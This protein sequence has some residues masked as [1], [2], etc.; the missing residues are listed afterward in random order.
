MSPL[1]CQ[2]SYAAMLNNAKLIMEKI[3]STLRGPLRNNSTRVRDG[4]PPGPSSGIPAGFSP[5]RP[6]KSC[7][8]LFGPDCVGG[9]KFSLNQTESPSLRRR[10]AVAKSIG[11]MDEQAHRVRPTQ[12]VV[13]HRSCNFP[14]G[15]CFLT[16]PIHLELLIRV[17]SYPVERRPNVRPKAGDSV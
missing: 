3:S 4:A 9:K 11:K 7:R 12:S 1:L 14:V 15:L 10:W 16:F 13:Y 6:R 2:L 17:S 5:S 8:I